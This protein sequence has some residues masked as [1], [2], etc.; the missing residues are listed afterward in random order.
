MNYSSSVIIEVPASDI[1]K[2]LT[3]DI[4]AWWGETDRV[5]N[6]KGDIFKVSWG[7]PWYLFEVIE[8]QKDSLIEWKCI[9]ANQI[10]SGLEG[11]QK[12]WVGSVVHWNMELLSDHAT[13][14]CIEHRGLTEA[15]TCYEFC[16]STWNR[17]LHIELK[18][19]L[20]S[21]IKGEK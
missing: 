5:I 20:E 12:E 17:F 15:L 13:R 6:G 14:L 9:D 3:S 18:N 16:S 11:V 4:T 2:A 19:Y 1:F 7:A 10:I 21:S 8:Y